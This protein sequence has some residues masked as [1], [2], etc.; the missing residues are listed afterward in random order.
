MRS[1]SSPTTSAPTG[2]ASG[3]RAVRSSCSRCRTATARAALR[4]PCQAAV[5]L[6]T[7]GWNDWTREV[8]IA[9]SLYAADFMRLG[10]QIEALLAA[11]CRIFHVDV[12]DGQ[13]IPPITIGPI[14]VQSVASAIHQAGGRVDCHLMIVEPERHFEQVREAGATASPSTSRCVTTCRP[15]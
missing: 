15:R 9:P 10:D 6:A 14:V 7:V 2:R 5:R 1:A 4:R 11:G 12:G 13:F 3:I 8:E